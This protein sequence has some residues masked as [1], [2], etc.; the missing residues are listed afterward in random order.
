MQIW[1]IRNGEKY[2]PHADY[3]IRQGIEN[4]QYTAETPAWHEG[5]PAWTTLG[6]MVVFQSAFSPPEP[7]AAESKIHGRNHP[8]ASRD[9]ERN[10][11]LVR[12][13]WARW[14]DLQ[15]YIAAWWLVLYITNRDVGAIFSNPWIILLQLVP[16]IPIEA[17]LITRYG[18][19]PG[20]WLLGITVRND[21]GSPLSI[22][23]SISR[24]VRVLLAGLGLGWGILSP[25]CQGISYW[26]TRRLGR[27]LWD[28]IGNH[29]I[30]CKPVR[31]LRYVAVIGL[32]Y[33][34]LQLQ[35]AVLAPY[36]IPIYEKQFPALKEQFEKSA[37]SYFPPRHQV[38]EE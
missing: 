21:D 11:H 2:G 30:D 16:W 8:A 12:R 25:V 19:T 23:Q 35:F 31:H 17:F 3:H 22:R 10:L 26:L 36:I 24:A 32:I 33:I 6:E 37:P 20:K 7:A 1:L 14:M 27:T 9:P 4:G 13:F 28:R 29:H 5:L 15:L 18:T 38:P 34:A